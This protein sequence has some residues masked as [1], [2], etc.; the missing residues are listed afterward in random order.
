MTTS[1]KILRKVLSGTESLKSSPL[2]LGP[3]IAMSWTCDDKAMDREMLPTTKT[4]RGGGCFR[5]LVS[6]FNGLQRRCSLHQHEDP[7]TMLEP[8][9]WNAVLGSIT[10]TV[11]RGGIERISTREILQALSCSERETKLQISLAAPAFALD[12][13]KLKDVTMR[14]TWLE[15]TADAS[16]A[17]AC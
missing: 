11:Y 8:D 1:N 13:P 3:T 12:F 16:S 4:S 7:H 14:K 10:G 9:E 6:R 5:L 2:G 17:I 15:Q